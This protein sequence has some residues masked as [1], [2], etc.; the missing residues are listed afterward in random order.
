M[1]PPVPVVS[2]EC[3]LSVAAA[4]GLR[5]I[6]DDLLDAE[7][8]LVALLATPTGVRVEQR[9]RLAGFCTRVGRLAVAREVAQPPTTAQPI[10]FR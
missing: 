1:S 5:W 7:Q 8:D 6:L 10:A 4:Q 3:Q 9:E 2:R